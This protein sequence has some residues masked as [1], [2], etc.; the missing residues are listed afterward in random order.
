MNLKRNMII[1]R[2]RIHIL[3]RNLTEKVL[4]QLSKWGW[5]YCH[6]VS[7]SNNTDDGQIYSVPDINS[8]RF[9]FSVSYILRKIESTHEYWFETNKGKRIFTVDESH[10]VEH[11]IS[12]RAELE[13]F[14]AHFSP[15]Q[16]MWVHKNAPIVDLFEEIPVR[17]TLSDDIYARQV[18]AKLHRCD[19]QQCRYAFDFCY[20]PDTRTN[21]MPSEAISE[22]YRALGV[23]LT[24]KVTEINKVLTGADYD[25]EMMSPKNMPLSENII[26]RKCGLPVFA[27]AKDKYQFECLVHGEIDY[28][29]IARVDPVHYKNVLE[30]TT[31]ILEDL[32]KKSCPQ[33]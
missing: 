20:A 30:N 7:Y 27:S 3:L 4:L 13:S 17:P 19:F 2:C 33:D 26:C 12:Y 29:D 14:Y 11:R 6:R 22:S 10:H 32:I 28:H 25:G 9:V 8:D 24:S 5:I 23:Q 21:R 18:M 16:R 15:K 1:L 31:E